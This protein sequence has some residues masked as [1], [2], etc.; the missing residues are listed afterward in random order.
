MKHLFLILAVCIS[1]L[2]RAQEYEVSGFE[3]VPNDITAR[4]T[5]RV[6]R[7]G[8]M[9]ALIKV[10]VPD[11]ITGVR[12][13]YIGEPVDYGMEKWIYVTDGCKEI[14]ILFEK[15]Y[16]LHYRFIDA[17]YPVVSQQMTYVM[18][19]REAAEQPPVTQAPAPQTRQTPVNETAPQAASSVQ[20]VVA[21]N[22]EETVYSPLEQELLD[23]YRNGKDKDGYRNLKECVK[24]CKKNS[25]NRIAQYLLGLCYETQDFGVK[26]SFPDAISYLEQSAAQGY[27]PAYLEL[28]DIYNQRGTKFSSQSKAEEWFKKAAMTGDA[29]AQFRFGEYYKNLKPY[30]KTEEAKI[31]LTKSAEQGHVNAMTSLG[32]ACLN[33]YYGF[34]RNEQDGAKW[35]LLAAEHGDIWSQRA[36]AECYRYGKGVAQNW[37]EALKWYLKAAGD[38][39]EGFF[40]QQIL[41]EWYFN[42]LPDEPDHAE[43][44]KWFK[45]AIGNK[46]YSLHNSLSHFRLGECYEKGLGVEK[47]VDKAVYHYRMAAKDNG[48]RHAKEVQAALER[49]NA[50]K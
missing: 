19:L 24:L 22:K 10:Y 25:S 18:K 47:D 27:I 33:G 37:E 1:F 21:S 46:N 36:I 34:D 16:P 17:N 32:Y 35:Y 8:R 4:T 49:L 20:P 12:G 38:E 44:V 45:K 39:K 14:E 31:W 40:A 42:G 9:C 11:K 28:G 2:A 13:N 29:M 23:A 30:P 5:L 3:I 48:F 43:A 15:H 41:G 6:D 7:N 26:Q 50:S